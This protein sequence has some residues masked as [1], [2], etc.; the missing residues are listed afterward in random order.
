MFMCNGL[1]GVFLPPAAHPIVPCT[2]EALPSVLYVPPTDK[3]HSVVVVSVVL[4]HVVVLTLMVGPLS[5][6]AYV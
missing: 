3:L 6:L 4:V 2:D 5:F 1:T